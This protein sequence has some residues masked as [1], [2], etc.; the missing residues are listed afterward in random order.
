MEQPMDNLSTRL[1]LVFTALALIAGAAP[2]PI[3]A[4]SDVPSCAKV[5]ASWPYGSLGA[6]AGADDGIVVYTS[7]RVLEVGRLTVG[8]SVEQLGELE[9]PYPVDRLA[10]RGSTVI[11]LY[12]RGGLATVD[13]SDPTAPRFLGA[14]DFASDVEE[15]PLFVFV[16]QNNVLEGFGR[17][18]LV[19]ALDEIRAVELDTAMRPVA[20]HRTGIS[21]WTAFATARRGDSELGFGFVADS[22]H[23]SGHLVVWDVSD[24]RT[25]VELGSSGSTACGSSGNCSVDIAG[26]GIVGN[27]AVVVSATK[28]ILR[29]DTSTP[30]A[31]VLGDWI[32][33]PIEART[34]TSSDSGLYVCSDRSRCVPVSITESGGVSV[35]ET[36]P[37]TGAGYVM[38]FPALAGDILLAGQREQLNVLDTSNFAA[39]LVIGSVG[40]Y[41]QPT[42]VSALGNAVYVALRNRLIVLARSADGALVRRGECPLTDTTDEGTYITSIRPLDSTTLYLTQSSGSGENNFIVDVSDQEHP[43]VLSTL[44]TAAATRGSAVNGTNVAVLDAN[45]TL[46]ILDLSEPASPKVTATS[47]VDNVRRLLALQGSLLWAGDHGVVRQLDISD[48]TS[49]QVVSSWQPPGEYG[50]SIDIRQAVPREGSIWVGGER[51]LRVVLFRLNWPEGRDAVVEDS[52]QPDDGGFS[53]AVIGFNQVALCGGYPVVSYYG[54]S[55]VGVLDPAGSDGLKF[56]SP[57]P[58]WGVFSEFYDTPEWPSVVV[59]TRDAGVEVLD[60]SACHAQPPISDFTWM[61]ELPKAFDKVDLTET[62]SGFPE[63]SSWKLPP[64]TKILSSAPH[65]IAHFDAPGSYPVSLTATNESG[66]STVTKH[67]VVLSEP[68]A[69]AL[70]DLETSS[71]LIVPVAASSPGA[72]GTRWKT[73]LTLA[74]DDSGDVDDVRLHL[75]TSATDGSEPLEVALGLAQSSGVQLRDVVRTAMEQDPAVGALFITSSAPISAVSRTFNDD[76]SGTYGQMV[77]ALPLAAA[78]AGTAPAALIQLART[79]RFRTNLGFVNLTDQALTLQAAASRADGSSLGTW[80]VTLGP[81]GF[82]QQNDPLSWL[83]SDAVEDAFVV[84]TAADDAARYVTYASVVDNVSGDAVFVL[85]AAGFSAAQVVPAAV[86]APGLYG[87]N[88]SSELELYNPGQSAAS[89]TVELIPEAGRG[90]QV[91]DPIDVPAGSAR[92]IADVVG[93]LFGLTGKGA[94]AVDCGSQAVAVTS[95]TFNDPGDRTYG[96][97][98]PGRGAAAFLQGDDPVRLIGLESLRSGQRLFRTNVGLVNLSDDELVVELHFGAADGDL[99]DVSTRTASVPARTFQQL[100]DVFAATAIDGPYWVEIEPG[101]EAASFLAYASVT[102]N[103]SG[104]P[105]FIEPVR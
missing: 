13:I 52:W 93:T 58:T 68:A 44:P 48:P 15:Y 32:P 37:P 53:S 51:S 28:G 102:D 82:L 97:F 12:Q 21:S 83:T 16:S 47:H 49:P 71:T 17:W 36:F 105:V 75:V 34:F 96:Q 42:A 60:L 55:G 92:R 101:S 77:P 30:E 88:W 50:P 66:S 41:E 38:A 6:F 80:P 39:P 2:P 14:I 62:T 98:I 65:A 20:I 57:L 61:P 84:V 99:T 74:A 10:V 103:R 9:L 7:G 94:L 46:T 11:L 76:P 26:I 67:V 54:K 87:T 86:S 40:F 78:R 27:L 4:A 104:D 22:G 23:G 69:D 63:W 91:S 72:Q 5:E 70:P 95:R 90:A 19:K 29:L 89:C 79:A 3:F 31:P 18:V 56:V 43:A 8:G 64:K 81:Y 33:L 25:P 1:V 59:G 35:G 73:D 24:P 100:D 45:G 85:P